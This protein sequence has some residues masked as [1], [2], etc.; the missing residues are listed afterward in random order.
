[1][2]ITT[3]RPGGGEGGMDDG[4]IQGRRGRSG[5]YGVWMEWE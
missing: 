4:L 3:R 2:V 5:V 1:M